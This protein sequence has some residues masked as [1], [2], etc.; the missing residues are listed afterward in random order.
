[1][2][3]AGLFF[4]KGEEKDRGKENELSDH[5]QIVYRKYDDRL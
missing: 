5:L 1:L 3:A 2:K 4:G